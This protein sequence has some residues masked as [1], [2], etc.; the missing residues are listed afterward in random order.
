MNDPAGDDVFLH[1]LEVTVREDLAEAETTPTEEEVLNV[2]VDQ[3]QFD[4]E[5]TERYEVSLRDLLG[6]IETLEDGPGRS[7]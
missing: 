3:W 6:A 1:E 7:E 4:P 2:P 5:D